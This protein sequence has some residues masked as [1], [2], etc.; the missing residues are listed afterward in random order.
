MH[1]SGRR[2]L[3]KAAPLGS[4]LAPL[5]AAAWPVR[6]KKSQI[7]P[8]EVRGPGASLPATAVPG[9]PDA[10]SPGDE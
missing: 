6:A 1:R 8:R 9:G 2:A 4:G 10:A 7:G 5:A 3:A